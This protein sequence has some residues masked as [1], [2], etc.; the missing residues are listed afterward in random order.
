MSGSQSATLLRRQ[1]GRFLRERRLEAGLTIAQ[2]AHEVQLSTAALQRMETGRPQKLRK[3]DVREL[4]E[5]YDVDSDETGRA[6][7]LAAKAADNPDITAL[8]GMF[9]NAFNMYVGMEAAARSLISYQ[10]V[11][12]GLLQTA[13][14]ARALI[15]SYPGYV[16]EEVDRRVAVR[17][18]RQKILTRKANP[19]RL[20]VLLSESALRQVVGTHRVMSGQLRELAEAGKRPNVTIRVHPYHGGFPW[21]IVPSQFVIIEFGTNA[22]GQP[23]E[24]PVVYLDGGMSSDIYLENEDDVRKYHELVEVIRQTALDE[25][26]T[27]NLLRQVAREHDG[28]C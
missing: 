1:L 24:P 25:T 4:C 6:I 5:L 26:S 23:V 20:E 8:G 13:D 21:G 2:A 19:V 16:Q 12:P 17:L 10:A 27:R 11:V 14:Y 15:S 18:R 7:G 28:E 22:D 3:Q 9:S